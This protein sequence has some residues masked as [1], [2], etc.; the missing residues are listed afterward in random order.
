[1]TDSGKWCSE[2]I[3]TPRGRFRYYYH[4]V[5]KESRWS[6]PP[7]EE[8]LI[9]NAGNDA[10][11]G[12]AIPPRQAANHLPRNKRSLARLTYEAFEGYEVLIELKDDTQIL[13]YLSRT[14]H[15]WSTNLILV[16]AVVTKPTQ[17]V[18]T[19]LNP[20]S[21]YTCYHPNRCLNLKQRHRFQFLRNQDNDETNGTKQ[22]SKTKEFDLPPWMT[23]HDAV[24]VRSTS[25]RYIELPSTL[26]ASLLLK[27]LYKRQ[28]Y[29]KL[30]SQRT[31]RK[32]ED[33]TRSSVKSLKLKVAPPTIR[34]HV[35]DT[36]EK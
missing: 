24:T 27:R 19:N 32:E 13:G 9:A 20:L 6:P 23:F 29:Q 18:I 15:P 36:S 7:E 3:S 28:E 8:Q 10:E 2:I 17:T 21:S 22:S 25:I 14:V 5:T 1:M 12:D 33:G 35:T 4:S 11:N 30:K 34:V 26:N 16:D 31:Y